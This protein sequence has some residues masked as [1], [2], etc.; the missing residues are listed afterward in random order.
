M[1]VGVYIC[2]GASAAPGVDVVTFEPAPWNIER[3]KE[4]IELNESEAS[5]Y[6]VALSNSSGIAELS[7]LEETQG[8][9]RHSIVDSSEGETITVE[10]IPGDDIVGT[11]QPIPNIVKIDVEGAEDL[12]L[13]GLK[14]TLRNSNCRI[15]YCEKH[16]NSDKS[17]EEEGIEQSL[18]LLRFDIT[19]LQTAESESI[20]KAER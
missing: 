4:N 2:F 8:E 15:V 14:E 11:E 6:K 20:V 18:N 13:D 1:S 17:Q 5:V 7:V 10:T 9:Q 12:V 3:I 16:V 19:T